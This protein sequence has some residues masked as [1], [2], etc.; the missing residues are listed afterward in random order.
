MWTN[1]DNQC[2]KGALQTRDWVGANAG[3]HVVTV[4]IL[5][6][7]IVEVENMGEQIKV[8]L[9]MS[10]IRSKYRGVDSCRM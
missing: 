9:Q 10:E 3:A 5:A 4:R 1:E 8:P 2:K 7:G 6:L